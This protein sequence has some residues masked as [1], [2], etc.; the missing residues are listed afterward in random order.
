M[1]T[2]NI[3]PGHFYSCPKEKTNFNWFAFELACEINVAIPKEL[4]EY[5]AKKSYPQEAIDSSCVK[6]AKLLQKVVLRKLRKEIPEMELSYTDVE[7]AFPRLNDRTVSKL[8]ACVSKA[9]GNLLDI[10]V[11][12]PVA[13]ITNKDKYSPKFDDPMYN[14]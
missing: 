1:P 11:V 4:R 8:L 9:W 13:C 5:L 2:S 3:K 12:C 7:E 10:C 14:E 6:L